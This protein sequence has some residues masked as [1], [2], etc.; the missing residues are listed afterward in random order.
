VDFLGWDHYFGHRIDMATLEK[1]RKPKKFGNFFAGN[2]EEEVCERRDQQR[3]ICGKEKGFGLIGMTQKASYEKMGEKRLSCK[4]FSQV[5]F[6]NERSGANILR[7]EKMFGVMIAKRDRTKRRYNRISPYYDIMEWFLEKLAFSRWRRVT[8]DS[9]FGEN[10]LEV[11]VGTGKNF[12]FYPVGKR[13]VAIDFSRGMLNKALKKAEKS[14]MEVELKDMD[15]QDLQFED[16]SFDT[17]LAS[18]VFCSVPDPI[19]GLREIKR[20]CKKKGRIILLEHVRPRGK[21]LGKIFDLLNVA[22][23]ALMGVNINRDTVTNMKRVGLDIME[24]RNLF[25]DIVKLIIALP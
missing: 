22:T 16:Q 8:F 21:V 18:F 24:E 4:T 12:D 2:I 23:L 19:K 13:L 11:G 15:V 10:I 25:R 6:H 1:G 9:L 5:Q 14:G 17:V 20:V 7:R 3:R